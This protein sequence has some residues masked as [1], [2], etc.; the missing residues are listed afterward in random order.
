MEAK[1]PIPA[2]AVA[3]S[4][5]VVVAAV[6]GF[7]VVGGNSSL[8]KN[9]LVRARTK[10]GTAPVAST[11]STYGLPKGTPITHNAGNSFVDPRSK[12]PGS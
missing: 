7:Y 3:L 10:P 2:W 4:L 5:I 12:P 9:A 6:A 8:D 1:K 11:E